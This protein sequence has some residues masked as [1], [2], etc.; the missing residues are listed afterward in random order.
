MHVL[1]KE[2]IVEEEGEKGRGRSVPAFYSLKF[3]WN[4]VRSYL[5]SL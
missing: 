4:S 3:D 2:G 5:T 1:S